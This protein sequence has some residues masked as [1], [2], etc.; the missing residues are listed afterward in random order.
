ML[1][2]PPLPPPTPHL[3]KPFV[4]VS[5]G[6]QQT[7]KRRKFY[8]GVSGSP[9]SVIKHF[10]IQMDGR[11]F[12]WRDVLFVYI[13]GFRIAPD[14]KV[15]PKDFDDWMKPKVWSRFAVQYQWRWSGSNIIFVLSKSFLACSQITFGKLVMNQF[16]RHAVLNLNYNIKTFMIL[17]R[18]E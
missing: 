9:L 2:L 3:Y 15:C 16:R 18:L 7:P 12:F 10:L 5:W 17:V 8:N 14:W 11:A 13:V 4:P 6:W 1:Q